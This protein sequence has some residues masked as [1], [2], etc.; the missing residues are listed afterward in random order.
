MTD[1]FFTAYEDNLEDDRLGLAQ[2]VIEEI[3]GKRDGEIQWCREIV[4]GISD[5]IKDTN[6]CS[7]RQLE[8]LEN[9]V[10]RLEGKEWE[11][12]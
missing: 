6:R 4:E 11:R 5:T 1:N 12:G 8:A 7:D 2:A 3:L 9:I 10:K